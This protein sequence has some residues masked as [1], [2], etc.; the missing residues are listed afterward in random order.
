MKGVG[1]ISIA[2]SSS[3]L[4]SY[5]YACV[6][7]S[8]CVSVSRTQSHLVLTWVYRALTDLHVPCRACSIVRRQRHSP[9]RR[10]HPGVGR[11]REQRALRILRAVAG[12]TPGGRLRRGRPAILRLPRSRRNML[13]GH[14]SPGWW[15][16]CTG[17]REMRHHPIITSRSKSDMPFFTGQKSP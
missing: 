14:W 10:R 5:R 13:I 9:S 12:A 7:V 3:N 11:V 15:P 4:L 2:S 8:H 17:H 1:L 16:R 6:H